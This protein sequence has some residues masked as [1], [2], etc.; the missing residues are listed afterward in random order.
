MK[1]KFNLIWAA[2]LLPIFLLFLSGSYALNITNSTQ[3]HAFLSL[4][5]SARVSCMPDILD[6]GSNMKWIICR[7][8][9]EGENVSNIDLNS[10]V[11]GRK[12]SFCSLNAEKNFFETSD[13]DRNGIEVALG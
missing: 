6:A 12:D 9:L 4:L 8:E 5:P 1:N 13:F 11:L 10:V 2:A 3:I 7:I